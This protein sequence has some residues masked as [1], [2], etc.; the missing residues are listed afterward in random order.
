MQFS[1]TCKKLG[2]AFKS[3]K[4]LVP[5]G[6]RKPDERRLNIEEKKAGFVCIVSPCGGCKISENAD[7]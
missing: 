4:T 2:G 7:Y 1:V 5:A 3:A 6:S